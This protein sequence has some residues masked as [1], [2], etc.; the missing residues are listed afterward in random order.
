M[1]IG[2]KQVPTI[3]RVLWL[4]FVHGSTVGTTTCRGPFKNVTDVRPN[5]RVLGHTALTLKWEEEV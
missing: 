5:C 1:L 4:G 2:A 3:R